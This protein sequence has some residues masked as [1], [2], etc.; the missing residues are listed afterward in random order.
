[1]AIDAGVDTLKEAVEATREHLRQA[2]DGVQAT[3][4]ADTRLVDGFLTEA[5]VRQFTFRVD[6]PESLGGTDTAPNPVE[7]VLAALG[8]CQEIV[9][10]TYA[11]ILDI[12]LEGVAVRVTGDLDPRSFFGVAEVPAGFRSV[13]FAVQITS[14]APPERVAQLIDAVNRHCPV[15]D[16]LQRPLPVSGHY[17]LNGRELASTD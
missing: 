13:Q 6:E 5:T 16:I 10:A 11:R 3:F 9:Y 1:M 8:T 17:A 14:A 2:E 4:S 7:Y 15:L 12:P